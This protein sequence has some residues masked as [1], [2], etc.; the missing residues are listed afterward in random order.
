MLFGGRSISPLNTRIKANQRQVTKSPLRKET[1]KAE[2]KNTQ[3]KTQLKS[4]DNMG[5]LYSLEDIYSQLN[6]NDFDAF[7]Q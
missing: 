3:N 7:P 4:K 2:A 1:T 5:I 6:F